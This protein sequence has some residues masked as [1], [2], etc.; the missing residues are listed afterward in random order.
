M[1]KRFLY[2]VVY[3]AFHG[4]SLSNISRD[5][6]RN[7]TGGGIYGNA[8]T[9]RLSDNGEGLA[10]PSDKPGTRKNGDPDSIGSHI[11]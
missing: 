3:L 10:Q 9:L 4:T 8:K 6:G 1:T 2:Y 11:P 7:S 5:S